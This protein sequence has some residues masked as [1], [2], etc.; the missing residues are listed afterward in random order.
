MATTTELKSV[1]R[2][3]RRFETC[4][5][6]ILFSIRTRLEDS[7]ADD[8]LAGPS[9]LVLARWLLPRSQNPFLLHCVGLKPTDDKL[10]FTLKYK[11]QEHED[12][13][14]FAFLHNTTYHPTSPCSYHDHSSA[15][16]SIP[17][18]VCSCRVARC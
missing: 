1:S 5:Q 10:G 15:K 3:V 7:L 13:W 2:R 14:T 16:E 8:F 12:I 4:R 18:A 11:F 17:L 6:M 9:Q